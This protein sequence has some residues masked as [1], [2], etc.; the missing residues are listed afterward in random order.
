MVVVWKELNVEW[1]FLFVSWLVDLFSG[2]ENGGLLRLSLSRLL[3]GVTAF[4]VFSN[5]LGQSI[6]CHSS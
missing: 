6:I 1:V 5:Q 3:E 4:C 2:W